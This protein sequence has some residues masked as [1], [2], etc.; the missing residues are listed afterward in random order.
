MQVTVT[1]L[2]DQVFYLD[3]SDDME[4]E[5]FKALCEFEAGIAS[6]EISIIWNGQPLLDNH[7]T[8]KEYGIVNGDMVL[9][10]HITGTAGQ[11][12]SASHQAATPAAGASG[13]APV[14]LIDFGGIPLPGSQSPF[15]MTPQAP[16]LPQQD[17][18]QKI[19]DMFLSN[20]RELALLKERNPQLADA[21][22][23]GSLERFSEVFSRQH[24]ERMKKERERIQ[25][26][27][28]D[29]F[30]SR[31][32]QMIAEEIRLKNIE[33]NMETAIEYA[34][35]SFGQVIMLYIDCKVNGYPVKAFVD[36]GAQMTIMSQSCAE[37]CHIK[38]LIDTRWAGVAKG[39][40]IQNIIGR[41]HLCQ[42][43]IGNA[44]L[45]SSFSILEDQPM[46][47]LLGLDMLKRH[48][49]C[50]DLK[51]NVLTIGTTGTQTRF[52][53]EVEL[54]DHAR[55][56]NTSSKDRALMEQEQKK[57]AEAQ[58]RAQRGNPQP[59]TSQAVGGNSNSNAGASSPGPQQQFPEEVVRQLMAKGFPRE[60]VVE[61]LRKANGNSEKALVTL[62]AKSLSIP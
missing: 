41:V 14:P 54:P 29:P 32:Q 60:S 49:C 51:N 43:E 55:L 44:F 46:D 9:L 27:N 62:L 4:L 61:E 31:A 48:Q 5:N 26:I 38:R 45:Q 10:Q 53:T 17:D 13:S 58:A 1:T 12:A 56:N 52:L 23:S 24:E 57:L 15:S 47:M 39:V 59:G 18:P 35:E 50:I 34:P 37:R 33:T 11:F 8:L 25:L 3:V 40:G 22:L 42:I 30:D 21:L 16:D 6:S 19:R 7:K 20:P 36:S 2:T 28:A